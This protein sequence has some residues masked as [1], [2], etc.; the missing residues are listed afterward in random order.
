MA[1]RPDKPRKDSEQLS[2]AQSARPDGADESIAGTVERVTFHEPEN[3][4]C[5]LRVR[6]AGQRDLVSV[7]GRAPAISEGEGI[8]AEGRYENDT[9]HGVQFKAREL[10]IAPPSTREGIEKYLAS[11]TVKGVG[12]ELAKRLVAAFGDKV[13][14]VVER[15]PD[16]LREIEGVGP[17]RAKSIAAAIRSQQELRE[18][19]LFLHSHGLGAAR[20]IRIHRRYG[21]GAIAVI[22]EDPYRLAREIRGIG[23]ATADQ[24]ARKLGVEPTARI[25]LRAGL[26][27]ALVEASTSG[28]CALP[29]TMLL[30]EAQQLLSCDERELRSI[31]ENEIAS[32]ELVRDNLA[33]APAIFIPRLH[34]AE[35]E[36]AARLRALAANETPWP[37]IDTRAAIAWAEKH[38]D[39]EL[40][41]SQRD[42]V[43]RLLGSKVGVL[44]GGPGV[45]KTT[46]VC[47]FLSILAAKK[48]RVELAAPTGRAAKRLA[49]ATGLEART[50]HRLLE[51][52]PSRRES[53]GFKRGVDTPLD[54]DLVVVD[55]ASMIDIHLFAALLRAIPPHAALLLVGDADQLPSVGPGRVLADVIDSESVTCV[56]LSEIFRQA[57][58]SGIIQAAHEIHAGNV[59]SALDS[60]GEAANDFFF[61]EANDPARA[62]EV[63]ITVV[64][65]RIPGRFGLDPLRDVQVLVP[66][67]RGA[68]GTQQLNAGLQA[69]LNPG[70]EQSTSLEFAG[71]RFAAGD[72][73]IQTENDY[74]RD[75][76][77]GDLGIVDSVEPNEGIVGIRFD[78]RDDVIDYARSELD[79]LA[80]A[81]AITV[82]K[83]QGS[84][85]PAA[86]VVLST[87]HYPML[88]RRLVYTAVTRGKQLVVVVGQRRALEIALRRG[89][90][91]G[92]YSKLREWLR[93]AAIS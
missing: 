78:G 85:Y 76:F 22:R 19:M 10:A 90:E 84:E 83:S 57:A 2:L 14:D 1:R 37:S 26:H 65:D 49:E 35:R 44:T 58:E 52:D 5:V 75:V 67:H 63:V 60:A 29:E 43:D 77:N 73:V 50:L 12:P 89:D 64:R 8:R 70:A 20:A 79:A 33:G 36:A 41:P 62:A 55:E 88:E 30:Q 46:L 3:G 40:A 81:Y 53:G 45:G 59:P 7:V 66:M 48:V 68:V 56:E 24:L 42:A 54:C 9:K 32:D 51:V 25:R 80:L 87:Q 72:R 86:V 13:F 92:R 31:L 4:F 21:A 15:A 27:H 91:S 16:Q 39:I 23:F 71:I 34:R 6:V 18:L 61:I 82:H 28:H 11:G 74:D 38:L 47:T 69:A 93:P 17:K